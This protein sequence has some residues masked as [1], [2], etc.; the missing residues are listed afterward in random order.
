MVADLS[1]IIVRSCK[2]HC[3]RLY[4]PHGCWL[5]VTENTNFPILIQ[6]TLLS[7]CLSNGSGLI[8]YKNMHVKLQK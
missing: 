5:Q 8:A 1:V 4:A 2:D 3:L 6:K 7:K